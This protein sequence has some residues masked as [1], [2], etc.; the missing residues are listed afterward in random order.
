MYVVIRSEED[1][2]MIRMTQCCWLSALHGAEVRELRK[3]AMEL[4][5]EF[6]VQL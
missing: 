6:L 4:S 2:R 3:G 1:F 5:A